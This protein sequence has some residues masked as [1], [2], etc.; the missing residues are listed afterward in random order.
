M[1]GYIDWRRQTDW[2]GNHP[3]LVGWL[4]AFRAA[5]PAFDATAAK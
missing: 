4:E 1:L 3:S 5:A 2:R